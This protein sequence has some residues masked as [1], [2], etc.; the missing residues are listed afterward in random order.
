MFLFTCDAKQLCLLRT[1]CWIP[2]PA[3]Q[4]ILYRSGLCRKLRAGK[5][6][7]TLDFARQLGHFFVDHPEDAFGSLGRLLHKNFYL[8][9]AKLKVTVCPGITVLFS[10]LPFA[11]LKLYSLLL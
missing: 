2:S 7:A 10:T 3:P 9:N 5:S 4:D 11:S 6:G 8:G 1:G